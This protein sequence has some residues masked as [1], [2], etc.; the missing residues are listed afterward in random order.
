MANCKYGGFASSNL[1]DV[2][3]DDTE[4]GRILDITKFDGF[5]LVNLTFKQLD[6]SSQQLLGVVSAPSNACRGWHPEKG[7]MG[8]RTQ[9]L[10]LAMG[11]LFVG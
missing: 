3:E 1:N 5:E 4:L 10:T 11:L 8:N 6:M 2:I 7:V 9:E